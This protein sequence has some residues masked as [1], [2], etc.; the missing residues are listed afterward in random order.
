MIR[1]IA[2]GLAARAAACLMA[3]FLASAAQATDPRQA[4][5]GADALDMGMLRDP[6]DRA[7]YR[8]LAEELRCLVCQNQSL[9]DSPAGLAGDLRHEL[10]K[11]ILERRSDAEIK[12]FMVERYGEF[13][14]FRPPMRGS[15][16]VLWA[17]PFVLLAGG[18]LVWIRLRRRSEDDV[19]IDLE[20]ARRRLEASD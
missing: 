6:A 1:D 7:R 19:D 4:P 18:L 12:N 17:G 14:L 9:I 2:R 3:V 16:W 11:M 15:T 20:Q 10:E 8:T 5:P 13:V